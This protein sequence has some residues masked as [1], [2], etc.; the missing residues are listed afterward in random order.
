MKKPITILVTLIVVAAVIIIAVTASD[1]SNR[2]PDQVEIFAQCIADSGATFYGAFWCPHC[3]DQKDM[4]GR[5]ATKALPYQECSTAQRQQN[6]LCREEGIEGYPT[7][8]FADG[9][10]QSGVMTFAELSEETGCPLPGNIV[11]DQINKAL[12][13]KQDIEDA[14]DPENITSE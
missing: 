7:W 5:K 12:D 13:V 14:Q 1:K 8:E 9:S 6:S 2:E 10:R 11:N 3:N 4:F